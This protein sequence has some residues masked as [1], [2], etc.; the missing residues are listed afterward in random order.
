MAMQIF[1]TDAMD[2]AHIERLVRQKGY[3]SFCQWNFHE[4]VDSPRQRGGKM[5][6]GREDRMEGGGKSAWAASR[7]PCWKTVP[8]TALPTQQCR[9]P[10]RSGAIKA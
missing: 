7:R 3:A 6:G 5:E 8:L 9:G 1:S 2:W 4:N 10:R